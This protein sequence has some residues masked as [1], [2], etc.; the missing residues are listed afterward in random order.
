MKTVS[1]LICDK[2]ISF[3]FDE[4]E[5]IDKANFNGAVVG[6]ISAGF[7]STHDGDVYV[8][9]IC[10]ECIDKKKIQPVSNYLFGIGG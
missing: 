8:V 6:K 4:E 5:D 7:G 10:D 3:L 2:I 1:C 9:G